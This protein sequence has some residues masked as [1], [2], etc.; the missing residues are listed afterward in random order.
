MDPS[1]EFG[2]TMG[3][4]AEYCW[5]WWKGRKDGSLT[6]GRDDNEGEAEYCWLWWIGRKDGSL[7]GGRDDNGGDACLLYKHLPGFVSDFDAWMQG[8]KVLHHDEV[9]EGK[10]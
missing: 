7:T 9:G 4:D 8:N 2:M 10:K 5:L 6:G 3:G 1:Q